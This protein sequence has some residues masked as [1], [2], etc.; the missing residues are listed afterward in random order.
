[1]D[2]FVLVN[3][4]LKSLPQNAM[5]VVWLWSLLVFPSSLESR[6]KYLCNMFYLKHMDLF[7]DYWHIVV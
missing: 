3:I 1:M 4:F 6:T 7:N 5:D 2:T